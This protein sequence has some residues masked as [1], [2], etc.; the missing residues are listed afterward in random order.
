M[1]VQLS[2]IKTFTTIKYVSELNALDA[3]LR[4]LRIS[5]IS[6]IPTHLKI[7]INDSITRILAEL[8]D[9]RMLLLNTKKHL[10]N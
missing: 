2:D 5:K 4:L 10:N 7:D 8:G 1:I 3:H 9:L 6:D